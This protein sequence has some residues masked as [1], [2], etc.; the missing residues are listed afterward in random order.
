MD[1]NPKRSYRPR[2]AG[3]WGAG[4]NVNRARGDEADPEKQQ[5]TPTRS[6]TYH[7]YHLEISSHTLLLLHTSASFVI[8]ERIVTV[9]YLIGTIRLGPAASQYEQ[10]RE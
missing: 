8:V 2:R 6:C 9:T 10:P 1:V 4:A 5:P 7:V 3:S